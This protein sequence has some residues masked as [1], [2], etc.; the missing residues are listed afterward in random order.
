VYPQHYIFNHIPKTGGVSLLTIC[1]QNLAESE[2]SPHLTEAIRLMPAARFERYRLIAGHFGLLTQVGFC[3]SRYSMTMLRDPIRRILSS[4]VYWRTADEQNPVTAKAKEASFAGFVRYFMD[5]PSVILNT[6]T[7]H[8]AAIDRDFSG[9]GTD[10]GALLAAAKH[11]LVAFHFIGICEEFERS[12][13]LLCAELGWPAPQTIPHENRSR[14]EEQWGSIDRQTREILNERTRLDQELY[15]YGVSLLHARAQQGGGMRGIG[16]EPN[17]LAPFPLDYAP[18][19]RA[20]IQAVT[21]AWEGGGARMVDISVRFRASVRVPELSVGVQVSDA[22]G[23]IV[24][25]TSTAQE[26]LEFTYEAGRVQRA[27]FMAQCELPAGLY[28]VTAALSEPRRLGFHDHWID[29]AALLPVD[30]AHRAA[31]RY[32]RGMMLRGFRCQPEP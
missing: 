22:A 2:I 32:V 19:R 12:A 20:A 26:N 9:F 4:Y 8:F 24:W 6:Y 31:S 25:G 13:R 29:R 27:R 21:V 30:R 11:N 5:S 14:S 28:F 7:H 10:A 23:R 17:R 16:V 3:Q 15:T 1:R 18:E